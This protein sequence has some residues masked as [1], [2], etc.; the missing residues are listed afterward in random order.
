MYYNR[1]SQYNTAIG[2]NA[3]NLRDLGWNNT[4]LGAYCDVNGYGYYNCLAVGEAVTCTASSQAKIGNSSTSSI[5]GY[6][7]WNNISDGRYKQDI[8]EN[9]K[10]LDFILKLRPV[11]YQLDVSGLSKKLNESRNKETDKYTIQ[12]IAEKEQHVYTGFIVQEV[13]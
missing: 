6:V 10:G 9:V 12:A 11:T 3:G 1:N 7:G 5:G 8:K 13:E 2:Y 4:F